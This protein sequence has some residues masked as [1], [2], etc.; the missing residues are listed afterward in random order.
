[1]AQTPIAATPIEDIPAA[2]AI[3]RQSPSPL[4]DAASGERTA[5]TVYIVFLVIGAL[6]TAALTVWLYKATGRYQDAIK[7]DSDARIAEAGAIADSAKREAAQAN[8]RSAAL[9]AGNLILRRDVNEAAGRVATAQRDAAAAQKDAA[10]AIARQKKVETELARQR[11]RAARAESELAKLQPRSLST[12]QRGLLLQ[13]LKTSPKGPVE[14]FCLVSVPDGEQ[15]ATQIKEAL[16][17]SGWP[18]AG[19]TMARL[20]PGPPPGLSIA[21]RDRISLPAHAQGLL[22]A[23]ATAGIP[24]NLDEE[25][26]V[27][28]GVVRVIVGHKP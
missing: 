10:E 9:E 11:E 7:R 21:V 26:D 19:V 4:T 23:L 3:T 13:A 17:E 6:V 18:A 12:R 8:E 25:P 16:L 27:S 24:A 15:Y 1:M 28:A 2:T 22:Q 5:F 20:V 14:V